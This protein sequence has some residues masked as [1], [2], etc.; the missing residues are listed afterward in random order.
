MRGTPSPEGA[1]TR[2]AAIQR[3]RR[4]VGTLVALAL[5]TTATASAG[6]TPPTA[7]AT[8]R[9]TAEFD[10]LLSSAATLISWACLTWFAAALVLEAAAHL[11]GGLGGGCRAV[12][13][14][15]MPT[16]L[17]RLAQAALGLTMVAGPVSATGGATAAGPSNVPTALAAPV[18]GFGHDSGDAQPSLDRPLS[19]ASP[20]NLAN[21]ATAASPAPAAGAELDRP[22]TGYLPPPPRAPRVVAAAPPGV[23]VH[24][25]PADDGYAVRRGDALW[26]IVARHLGPQATAADVARAWPRW[27]AANRSV[28]GPDP[29]LIRPGEVLHPP[30]P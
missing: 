25:G 12:A 28:I 3:C 29:S 18:H 22:W 20:A 9:A 8:L 13:R 19:V 17:R 10:V 7:V 23:L 14:R 4:A 21:R 15:V 30:Q 27:Y 26:D 5:A 24:R 6:G 16:V 2:S 11:P 1:A